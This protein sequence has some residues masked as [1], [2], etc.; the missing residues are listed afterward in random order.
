MKSF[1][2][3]ENISLWVY[4][5]DGTKTM[6][7]T[8]LANVKLE[9]ELQGIEELT[10]DIP[11]SDQRSQFLVTD[12]LVQ[13]LGKFYRIREYD[14]VNTPGWRSITADARWIELTWRT[15]VDNYTVLGKT[16]SAGL[17][18][19]LGG[20][21][22]SVGTVDDVTTLY[23]ME[24]VGSTY[25]QLLRK[26]AAIV[27]RE[28]EFD[29]AAKTV[30]LKIQVGL[31]RGV[32]F[33]YGHNLTELRRKYKPPQATRLYPFGANNLNI[34][35][36][37]PT[38]LSYLENYDWYLAQGLTLPQAQA[39]YRKD[40][41]W[42]DDS[43]LV[44]LNL[45]DA[46]VLYLAQL[47]QPIVQYEGTVVDLSRLTDSD[48][49]DFDIGDTVSVNDEILNVSL[50][51]RV[52]RLIRYPYDPRSDQ[53]ELSFLNNGLADAIVSST[54]SVDYGELNILANSNVQVLTITA[55]SQ[56]WASISITTAGEATFVA[57]GT[58]KGT[59]TGTGTVTFTMVVDG[60][61]VGAS[62]TV[63]FT[64][65]NQVEFSWPTFAT[66]ID[67]GGHIVEWR[68]QVT[69]GTGTVSVPIG[70]ARAWLLAKGVVGIGIG[71][72]PNTQVD[73]VLL[74]TQTWSNA[75]EFVD[76]IVSAGM[77]P[78]NLLTLT[79]TV[80]SRTYSGSDFTDAVVS[81]TLV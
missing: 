57:G 37:S 77:D 51:T 32:G 46:A 31:N 54:L 14:D 62:Y 45:L 36:V 15:L 11:L 55:T 1:P 24:D 39:N 17:T 6:L 19:I 13:L 33:R 9:T 58:F 5:L 30:S 21:G 42:V 80:A 10:F 60:T 2:I 63:P 69:T 29:T 52:V 56:P 59:A 22:W 16:P 49:D 75:N 72:S 74:P 79:E 25:L 70:F 20:S 47:S 48:V 26:W 3:A 41:I 66:G 53:I 34:S 12:V 8:Q 38:G 28:L 7:F 35:G 73:D 23:S 27:D 50:L 65:G 76:I 18:Q 81:V 78:H 44:A 68:A 43:Y 71:L 40:L 64:D 61:V 67:E 4:G